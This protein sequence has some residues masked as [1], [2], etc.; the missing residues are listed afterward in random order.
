MNRLVQFVKLT[1]KVHPKADIPSDLCPEC[2]LC[3]QLRKFSGCGRYGDF[4][5]LADIRDRSKRT[6]ILANRDAGGGAVFSNIS[7]HL[8]T[9]RMAQEADGCCL[10]ASALDLRAVPRGRFSFGAVGTH[11]SIVRA[12]ACRTADCVLNNETMMFRAEASATRWR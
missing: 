1:V 9:F 2:L 6:A 12:V 4:V 3:P 10:D 5:P 11:S 8:K 7:K